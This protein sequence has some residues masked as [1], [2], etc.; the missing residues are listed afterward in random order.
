MTYH[1]VLWRRLSKIVN[2]TLNK[3]SLWVYNF[4]P[5][6]WRVRYRSLPIGVADT[7]DSRV[8][9]TLIQSNLLRRYQEQRDIKIMQENTIG[10]DPDSATQ[11]AAHMTKMV[12]Q[13]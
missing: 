9:K 13:R 4:L 3:T 7:I 2:W 12:P 1:V 6:W 10:Q 11:H 8:N 5:T